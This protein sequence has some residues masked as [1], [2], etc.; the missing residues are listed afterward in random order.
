MLSTNID[1]ATLTKIKQEAIGPRTQRRLTASRSSTRRKCFTV[2]R[3]RLT[4]EAEL[5]EDRYNQ[6]DVDTRG[7]FLRLFCSPDSWNRPQ[8]RLLQSAGR[9][10]TEGV[11]PSI[12]KTWCL[13]QSSQKTVTFNRCRHCIKRH[14]RKTISTPG[15]QV[16][17]L[18]TMGTLWNRKVREK[19]SNMR[20]EAIT[21]RCQY[22]RWEVN[23]S[24]SQSDN[25][26]LTASICMTR[27]RPTAFLSHGV[28]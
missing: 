9:R 4:S 3:H 15:I 19:T 26:L 8:K 18:M 24:T 20:Q 12:V 13:K 11:S 14:N 5:T 7:M 25:S 17:V 2:W 23:T 6:Q 22:L 21:R 28:T 16:P 27:Y 10:H 1:W